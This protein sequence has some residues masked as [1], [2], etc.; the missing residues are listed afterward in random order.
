MP[1]KSKLHWRN[2]TIMNKNI[3]T[4][5]LPQ[6]ALINRGGTITGTYIGTE[7]RIKRFYKNGKPD[8]PMFARDGQV[9]TVNAIHLK[10]T[11]ASGIKSTTSAPLVGAHV[12]YEIPG[13]LAWKEW[14]ATAADNELLVG[15]T[16]EIVYTGF[17]QTGD[18]SFAVFQ[19]DTDPAADVERMAAFVKSNEKTRNALD[20]EAK[21]EMAKRNSD[22][23]SR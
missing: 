16:V 12:C 9:K 17:K 22:G 15:D 11:S 18:V 7:K 8:R 19:V 10:L 1:H 6:V 20:K 4:P 14:C 21:V 23:G 13:H 3:K 5:Q 2:E